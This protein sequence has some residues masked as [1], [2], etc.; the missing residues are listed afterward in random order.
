MARPLALALATLP[1][2]A[3]LVATVPAG[4]T[5]PAEEATVWHLSLDNALADARATGRLILVDL[6]AEWCGWCK[7]LERDTFADP[8]FRAYADGRFVLLRV[9]VEDGAEGT[10]LRQ[11]FDTHRLP[12][13]LIVDRNLA[14]VGRVDGYQAPRAMIARLDA[15]LARHRE[16]IESYRRAMDD[17]DPSALRFV[18]DRLHRDSDGTRAAAIYERLLAEHEHGDAARAQLELALADAYRL[19][20]EFDDAEQ[21]LER[22]R[23]AGGEDPRLAEAAALQEVLVARDRGDCR[24][25]TQAVESLLDR[26]PKSRISIEAITALRTLERDPTAGCD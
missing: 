11:R 7:K 23:E 2:A 21:A 14:R 24:R 22:A 19:A 18:A 12:T 8:V 6:T 26:H 1:L 5:P 25:T 17:G 4:A 16:L 9:D 15:E 3:T 13:T 20:R 10:R